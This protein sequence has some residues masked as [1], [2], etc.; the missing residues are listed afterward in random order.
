MSPLIHAVSL[1]PVEEVTRRARSI[2]EQVQHELYSRMDRTVA[3]FGLLLFWFYL[4]M[5]LA[6]LVLYRRRLGA[7][8][9]R[10]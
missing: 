1:E 3:R 2:G 8:A 6:I 9:D 10:T 7:E 5:T 4:L